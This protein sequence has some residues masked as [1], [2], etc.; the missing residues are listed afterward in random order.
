MKKSLSD[1][2]RRKLERLAAEQATQA[3]APAVEIGLLVLNGEYELIKVSDAAPSSVDDTA[4]VGNLVEAALA[5]A[6]E[7]GE[8]VRALRTALQQDQCASA[9]LL[10]RELCGLQEDD[11]EARN[12]ASS[13]IH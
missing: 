1:D 4:D 13:R 2:M 7:R 5:I 6:Q 10:A 3:L 8:K 11:N 9:L 12:P